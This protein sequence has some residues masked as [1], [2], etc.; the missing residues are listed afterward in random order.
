MARGSLSM[1]WNAKSEPRKQKVLII[2]AGAAGMAMSLAIDGEKHGADWVNQ[3]TQGGTNLFRHTYNFF[4]EYGYEPKE[5]RIQ[6]SFG[7]GVEGFWTNMF[8]SPLLQKHQHDI[9]KFGKALR[10][11]RRF[12]FP[13]WVIP[14][15]RFFRLFGISKEFAQRIVYPLASVLM[16][17]GNEAEDVPCGVLQV[18]F[19]DPELKIWDFDPVGFMPPRPPMFAFPNMARFYMDWAAGLRA[20]GVTIRLNT[21]AINIIQRNERGIIVETRHMDEDARLTEERYHD[22]SVTEAFDKLVLCVPGDEA[23]RLLGETATWKEKAILSGVKYF[24]DITITHCDHHYFESRY[25][26]RFKES[27]CGKPVTKAQEEQIRFAKGEAGIHS[28]FRPSYC[29]YSYQS[30]PNK[31]ELSYDFSNFQYQFLPEPCSGK[32]P[33]PL[34][35]HVF[36]SRFMGE[37]FKDLWTI[38]QINDKAVLERRWIH[39]PSQGWKHYVRVLPYLRYINGTKNTLYAGAWTFAV[40]FR[41]FMAKQSS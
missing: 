18:L 40:S 28:G 21:Q 1:G 41:F 37:K 10:T 17:I 36:Q 8:P 20:K 13:L 31:N 34:D 5:I 16:G 9:K 19:D 29:T 24:D 33:L 2:G 4:R 25:E 35:R 15:K 12:R 39:Q 7:K 26:P 14:L 30:R 6:L 23:R 27:L 38:D 22:R 11:V 32:A 3:G